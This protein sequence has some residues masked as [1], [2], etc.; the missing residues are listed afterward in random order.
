MSA[1]HSETRNRSETQSQV[2]N[3]NLQDNSGV[4]LGNSNGNIITTTDFGAIDAAV[5]IGGHALDVGLE[6]IKQGGDVA[7]AGLDV[8]SDAYSRGLDLA[9]F[10]VDAVSDAGYQATDRVARFAENSLDFAD[11]IFS[12]AIASNARTLD[13][14]LAGLNTLAQNV[15][16]S[17]TQSV[18]Q[19]V[20]K[21]AMYAFLA[22]AA[23]LVL[24]AIAKGGLK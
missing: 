14:S 16:Q 1:S 5:D 17:A 19:G 8:A 7:I 24:P 23:I 21:V 20:Q 3:L 18:N 10:S 4:T 15:S 22:V 6:G 12:T 2:S 13:T 9:K 11:D